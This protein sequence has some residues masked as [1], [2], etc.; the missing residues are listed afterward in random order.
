MDLL[1]AKGASSPA[2]AG[3]LKGLP[4]LERPP[5]SGPPPRP[6]EPERDGVPLGCPKA[7]A[8]LLAW[9]SC[10]VLGTLQCAA[11][12]GPRCSRVGERTRRSEAKPAFREGVREATESPKGLAWP[13]PWRAG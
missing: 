3:C 7:E 1:G 13:L 8:E 6:E 4:L 9:S 10:T 2:A 11:P 5:S 12:S